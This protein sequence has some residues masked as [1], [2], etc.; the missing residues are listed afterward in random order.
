MTFDG[1]LKEAKKLR[2]SFEMEKAL[3]AYTHALKLRPNSALAYSE[4]ADVYKG[5]LMYDRAYDDLTR[6]IQLEPKNGQWY[7]DRAQISYMQANYQKAISDYDTVLK[8]DPK[9]RDAGLF[10]HRGMALQKLRRKD[11]AILEFEKCIAIGNPKPRIA[12]EASTNLGKL[13]ITKR[14][15]QKAV[16]TFTYMIQRYPYSSQGY[17]G[18]AEAF[19]KLGRTAEASQDRASAKSLDT[20]LDPALLDKH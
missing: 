10:L 5:L 11:D 7:K 12:Q 6:A 1:Y 14:E 13:Y 19:E 2:E 3:T 15:Y 9:T 17:Y 16:R 8:I 18:R 20:D 4:R